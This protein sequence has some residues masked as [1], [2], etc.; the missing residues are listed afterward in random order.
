MIEAALWEFGSSGSGSFPSSVPPPASP[1]F[2][3]DPIEYAIE[4]HMDWYL[5]DG[6]YGD[7]EN[8]HW[9]HYNS[10]VIQPMLLEIFEVLQR[11]EH[12]LAA[13]Y[14]KL[15]KGRAMRY[16]EVQERLISP[17]GTFPV[18]GRS[19][20]YRFGAFHHLSVMSLKHLLPKKLHQQPS[21][22]RAALT[23]VVKK[24]MEAPD[25][26]DDQGWLRIGAVGYQPSIGEVYITTG[27]LYLCTVGLLHLGLP[28]SDAFWND[29]AIDWSQKKIWSGTVEIPA[30]HA[31]VEKSLT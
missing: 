26:F 14:Y 16:A 19:S 24:V 23:A 25:T 22:V 1:S 20:A 27:S 2:Q 6:I 8:F 18:I 4:K 29:D 9:D 5:G 30:D 13:K 21:A 7:G 3:M 10:Y 15:V 17:E 11:K 12:P 28:P 31:R